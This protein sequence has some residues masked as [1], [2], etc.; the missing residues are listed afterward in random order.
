[1]VG[2]LGEIDAV[3]VCVRVWVSVPVVVMVTDAV[4]EG[5]CELVED[6]LF[7]CVWVVLEVIVCVDVVVSLFD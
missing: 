4:F 7:V 1:M 3:T 2:E 6:G 5:V